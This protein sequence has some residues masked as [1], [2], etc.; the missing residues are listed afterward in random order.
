MD[1]R[2]L[3]GRRED[4][5]DRGARRSR[6]GR[7]LSASRL[8]KP[9]AL[10]EARGRDHS[11]SP[12]VKVTLSILATASASSTSIVRL[13]FACVSLMI[14]TTAGVLA[15][16]AFCFKRISVPLSCGKSLLVAESNGSS[17]SAISPESEMV[18]IC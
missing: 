9:V 8:T 4:L 10:L 2:V 6:H 16:S 1:G 7:G 18:M 11:S 14:V 5:H 15:A 3:G 13:Y 12:T 17:L